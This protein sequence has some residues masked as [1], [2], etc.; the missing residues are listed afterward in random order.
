[1]LELSIKS[2]FK[3]KNSIKYPELNTEW[4]QK[5]VLITRRM[6]ISIPPERSLP[7]PGLD[8]ETLKLDIPFL[9]KQQ[10]DDRYKEG[11]EQ[12]LTQANS[13]PQFLKNE[14]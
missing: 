3:H 12:D 13:S 9:F 1:M 5:Y 10:V 11:I 6:T 7:L 14:P 8:K 4:G 2:L